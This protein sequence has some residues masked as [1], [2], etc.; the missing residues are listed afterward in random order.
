M[1][2]VEFQTTRASN[3]RAF[4]Q[5]YA[6]KKAQYTAALNSARTTTDRAQQCVFIKSALDA[7]KQLSV[8]VEDLLRL[9]QTGGC[10]L[11]PAKIQTLRDDIEKF[12]K[13]HADIQQGKDRIHSL[14]MSFADLDAK[15]LHTDGVNMFYFVVI[16]TG[17]LALVGLVFRSGIHRA[18]NAQ[19][20]APVVPRGF[21]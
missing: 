17:V 11:T 14:E 6:T 18:F 15:T 8:V 2:P 7:N 3:L 13:Q 21:A 12:K 10:E 9:N 16:G 19:S 4:E 1:N 5:N 20:V